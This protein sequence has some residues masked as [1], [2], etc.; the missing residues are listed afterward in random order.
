M[1]LKRQSADC[2]HASNGRRKIKI[3]EASVFIFPHTGIASFPVRTH[4][5]DEEEH[6]IRPAKRAVCGKGAMC[7]RTFNEWMNLVSS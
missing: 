1:H 6:D 4:Q 7:G 5:D 3:R 2:F